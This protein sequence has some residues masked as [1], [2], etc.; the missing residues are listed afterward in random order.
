MLVFVA[1]YLYELI[2]E[3]ILIRT[4][5]PIAHMTV[6][7]PI[8]QISQWHLFG[9]YDDRLSVLPETQLALVLQGTMLTPKNLKQSF[10]I[11]SANKAPAKV[12]KVGDAL[13]GDA[14]L[15]R[16]ANNEIVIRYQ[17]ELQSLKLPI[18]Q[19]SFFK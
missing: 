2:S 16:I 12:Y 10:A 5:T 11:V 4:V 3:F 18:T 13:P 8:A 1:M 17:G 19:L 15:E 9:A 14:T 6:I 7:K